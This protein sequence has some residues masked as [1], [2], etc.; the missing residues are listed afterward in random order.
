M[1]YMTVFLR[2]L[3]TMEKMSGDSARYGSNRLMGK[4]GD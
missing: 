2:K 1:I 3:K 4:M